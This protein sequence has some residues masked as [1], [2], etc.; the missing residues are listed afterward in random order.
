MRFS[1]HKGKPCDLCEARS[2]D[3]GLGGGFGFRGLA[4]GEVAEDAGEDGAEE[5]SEGGAVHGV[6]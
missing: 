3:A 6:A 5:E 1:A 2:E 4:E